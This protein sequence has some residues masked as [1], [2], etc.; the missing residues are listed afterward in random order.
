MAKDLIDTLEDNDCL[1]AFQSMGFGNLC[2][3]F[4]YEF[5]QTISTFRP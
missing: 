1:Q 4:P 2:Q 3:A 5:D